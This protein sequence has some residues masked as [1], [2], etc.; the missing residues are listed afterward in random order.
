MRPSTPRGSEKLENALGKRSGGRGAAEKRRGGVRGE[1]G[2]V[3]PCMTSH[4]THTHGAAA[5]AH[6]HAP[7]E[8]Q[9]PSTHSRVLGWH[10]GVTG[11][12]PRRGLPRGVLPHA[13]LT[14][15][16]VTQ[17]G[18]QCHTQ[19]GGAGC[20]LRSGAHRASQDGCWLCGTAWSLPGIKTEGKGKVKP[21]AGHCPCTPSTHSG[22]LQP[23][24]R[25]E[26]GHRWGASLLGPWQLML[27]SHGWWPQGRLL[28]PEAGPLPDGDST[29]KRGRTP[30]SR[31]WPGPPQLEGA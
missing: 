20:S 26:R 29:A 15:P 23:R 27:F 28:V 7:A 22:H 8:Q 5:H 17:K 2:A 3:S 10:R 1:Q 18:T 16:C 31:C 24:W 9:V 19:P 21:G 13:A 4:P 30:W 25:E 6:T 12:C 11:L 14:L